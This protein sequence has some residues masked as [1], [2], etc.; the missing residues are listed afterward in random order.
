MNTTVKLSFSE[1]VEKHKVCL[2][3]V[4]LRWV[5][6]RDSLEYRMSDV[7]TAIEK[8]DFLD[9]E[10]LIDDDWDTHEVIYELFKEFVRNIVK[11][12]DSEQD[13][14]EDWELEGMLLHDDE[15]F[16]EFRE[17]CWEHDESGDVLRDLMKNTKNPG[18]FYDLNLYFPGEPWCMSQ[19]EIV[20]DMKAIAETL[21]LDWNKKHVRDAL[22]TLR[23][24]ATYGG[25]LRIYFN[26]PIWDLVSG[27]EN[28]CKYGRESANTFDYDSIKFNGTFLIGIINTYN[29]SGMVEE[30]QLDVSMS[31][32]RSNLY[33]SKQEK[34]GYEEVFGASE[35]YEVDTPEF[36][37]GMPANTT[38]IKVNT[39]LQAH[40][41]QEAEYAA[42]FKAGKC[43][44][45]DMDFRR[46]RNVVYI[47]EP[48]CGWYCKDCGT[49]WID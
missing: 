6:Y 34:Y 38:S 9:L 5:D 47:N 4:I 18:V 29:G 23:V 2:P 20:S 43:T 35:N 28:G 49:F 24:N 16:D 1:L 26:A 40:N 22:Y 7:A 21:H 19:D 32:Q 13:G 36:C 17:W 10:N 42:T 14:M 27:D 15:L 45:G 39:S 3:S 44:T 25:A 33:L 11:N 48:P 30:M 37:F 46:H 8:N 41:A 31:F 12:H